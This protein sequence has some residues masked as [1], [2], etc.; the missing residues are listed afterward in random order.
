MLVYVRVG[1]AGE[2]YYGGQHRC[3]HSHTLIPG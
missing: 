1:P 3:R 2:V